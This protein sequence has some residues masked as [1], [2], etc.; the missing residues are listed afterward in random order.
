MRL[1]FQSRLLDKKCFVSV[2]FLLFVIVCY[3]TLF[4]FTFYLRQIDD[5]NCSFGH[6][7]FKILF[8]LFVFCV[9]MSNL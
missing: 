6:F 7:Y 5:Q 9:T 1:R 2:N 3:K 4:P 8:R